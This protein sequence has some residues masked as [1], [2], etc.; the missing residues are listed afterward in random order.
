MIALFFAFVSYASATPNCT[1]STEASRD[2]R[3]AVTSAIESA[4]RLHAHSQQFHVPSDKFVAVDQAARTA[5]NIQAEQQL[6]ALNSCTSD[7]IQVA[8]TI[9]QSGTLLLEAIRIQIDCSSLDEPLKED[10]KGIRARLDTVINEVFEAGIERFQNSKSQTKP[11]DDL[12]SL[13]RAL[14][15]RIQHEKALGGSKDLRTRLEL[16]YSQLCSA[17]GPSI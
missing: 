1:A 3:Q 14:Q 7:C 13:C 2:S 16:S 5:L 11:N 8:H 9:M 12:T 6:A 17:T 10:L 15:L 4:E